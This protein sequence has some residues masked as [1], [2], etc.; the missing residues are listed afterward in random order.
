MQ[1]RHPQFQSVQ[2]V[3][4][5]LLDLLNWSKLLSWQYVAVAAEAAVRAGAI[6]KERYGQGVKVDFKGDID[7]VTEVEGFYRR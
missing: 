3:G 2:A 6:Q 7:L 5:G 4:V 1:N